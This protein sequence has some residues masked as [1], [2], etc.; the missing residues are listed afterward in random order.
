MRYLWIAIPVTASLASGMCFASMTEIDQV[1]QK[2][3]QTWLAAAR[4]DTVRFVNYDDVT[5]N[6]NVIDEEDNA[7]DKGLQK[8]GES[9]NQMFDISGK[10]IVRCSIHPKMKMTVTVK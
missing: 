8:P 3:S 1:G 4:G 7:V 2:F 10:F 5:H 9:I 6:I